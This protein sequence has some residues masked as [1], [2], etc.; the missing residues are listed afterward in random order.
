[1]VLALE[2]WILEPNFG[3]HLAPALRL[4]GMA[5][6]ILALFWVIRPVF[7]KPHA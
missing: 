6:I 1:M 3:P 5:A 2:L 4:G 7:G